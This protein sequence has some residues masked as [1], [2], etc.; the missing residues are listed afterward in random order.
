M[1]HIF[2]L[3][4]SSKD[5][6][7]KIDAHITKCNSSNALGNVYDIIPDNL[8]MEVK[9]LISSYKFKDCKDFIK[10]NIDMVNFKEVL[11]DGN[12][13]DLNTIYISEEEAYWILRAPIN[14]II[15]SYLPDKNVSKTKKETFLVLVKDG[16]KKVLIG[17]ADSKIQIYKLIEEISY[18]KNIFATTKNN[19]FQNLFDEGFTGEIEISYDKNIFIVQ[20]I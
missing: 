4:Q 18:D 13:N 11:Y 15:T 14:K 12:I 7:D 3:Y 5:V 10:K 20:K 6:L 1:S 9:F 19:K 2:L 17:V 8:A 16:E